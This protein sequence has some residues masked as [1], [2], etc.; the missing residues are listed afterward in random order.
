MVL[1]STFNVFEIKSIPTVGYFK[2]KVININKI[3]T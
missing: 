3:V 1:S 2:K